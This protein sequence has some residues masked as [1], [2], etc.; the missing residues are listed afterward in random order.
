VLSAIA[1]FQTVEKRKKAWK[2]GESKGRKEG[3]R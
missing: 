2:E 3:R 1:L